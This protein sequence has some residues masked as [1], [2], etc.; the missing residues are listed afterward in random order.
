ML[1]KL[2]SG[3]SRKTRLHDEKGNL[4]SLANATKHIPL[5][6]T[7]G[8]LRL[9]FNYRPALP[10]I[11]YE[12]IGVIQESLNKGSRVLEFGSGMS[13]IWYAR[14]AG[15]VFSVEDYEPWFKKISELIRVRKLDNIH[16]SF[17]S[18]EEIYQTFM[19]KDLDGFDL[20]MVDGS[21]RSAC[22][23]H[24]TK[25]LKPGGILYLDNS[26]KHSS[27]EGGDTRLAE[28]YAL[29]FAHQNNAEI[30]YFTDLAPTQLFVQQG[31]MIRNSSVV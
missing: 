17:A 20:I 30:R 9:T 15:E 1:N 6:L 26:D 16:Y 29:E 18:T 31:L 3:K 19:S 25:L 23:V 14:H 24:A 22:I 27:A 8:V 4:I 13:T 5:A 11:S 21:V 10:W 28:Q 7:T 12:A 2:I